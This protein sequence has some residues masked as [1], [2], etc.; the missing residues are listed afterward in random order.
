MNPT[1][2]KL[3]EL[4]ADE[5]NRRDFVKQELAFA[6]TELISELMEKEEVSK[7]DLAKRIGKSRAYVTQLL[8]GARNMTMHTL[9]DLSFALGYVVELHIQPAHQEKECTAYFTA[10][11][12][13]VC[14]ATQF[15]SQGQAERPSPSLSACAIPLAA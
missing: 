5:E 1:K 15:V 9:A 7:A 8:S 13:P 14:I 11:A 3:D 12:M 2:S 4:L 6:A 10:S